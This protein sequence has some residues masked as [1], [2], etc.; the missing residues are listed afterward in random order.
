MKSEEKFDAVEMMREIRDRL[1]REVTGMSF[2][3]EKRYINER[4]S[5]ASTQAE[6]AVEESQAA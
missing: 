6:D 3:E 1:S 2:E 5:G 4:L